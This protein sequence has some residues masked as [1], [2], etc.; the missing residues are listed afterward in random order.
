MADDAVLAVVQLRAVGWSFRRK[1]TPGLQPA[2][3][4]ARLTLERDAE[5]AFMRSGSLDVP[6]RADLRALSADPHDK[7][8]VKVLHNGASIGF[9]D[10]LSAADAAPLLFDNRAAVNSLR[11]DARCIAFSDKTGH[12]FTLKISEE[13]GDGMPEALFEPLATFAR[14]RAPP[15]AQLRG[16]PGADGWVRKARGIDAREWGKANKP[17]SFKADEVAWLYAAGPG[18]EP[19]G[20]RVGKWQLF[21]SQAAHDDLWLEVLVA[22]CLGRLGCAAKTAPCGGDQRSAVIIVYTADWEDRQ[23]VLRVALELFKITKPKVLCYKTDAHTNADKYAADCPTSLYKIKP[24]ETQ[25][26]VDEAVLS[27]ARALVGGGGGG[28]QQQQAP[29][30]QPFTGTGRTL[31]SAPAAAAAADVIS[32]LSDSDDDAPAPPPAKA[33]KTAAGATASSPPKSP[34]AKAAAPAA[35]RTASAQNAATAITPWLR[36]GSDIAAFGE[37]DAAA[38]GIELMGTWAGV[39]PSAVARWLVQ[40]ASAS[41]R[42]MAARSCSSE[43]RMRDVSAR[44]PTGDAYATARYSKVD[45]KE[46][47]QPSPGK[48]APLKQEPKQEGGANATLAALHAER[49]ARQRG[50]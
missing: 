35:T 28:A 39:P 26:T 50:A 22:L 31:G 6:A 46:T 21:V 18:R 48:A 29:R 14:R 33:A 32:L 36:P 27:E 43:L 8:A 19:N 12:E 38:I 15:S 2:P 25:L 41:E 47:A 45:Q 44:M 23:D 11:L 49:A 40:G 30:V 42:V 37:P 1:E 34:A 16:Q 5:S 3:V 24:G 13:P 9:L 7:N 17:S 10:R 4:G 20:D